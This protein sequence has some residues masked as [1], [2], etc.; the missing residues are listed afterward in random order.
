MVFVSAHWYVNGSF[1]DV[2]AKPKTIYDFFG[3]PAPLYQVEYPAPGFP[4]AIP[5]IEESFGKGYWKPVERGLDHGVWTTLVHLF[6]NADVPVITLSLNA[7]LSPEEHF[8]TGRKL[9]DLRSKGYLV[10]GGGN[11]VHDL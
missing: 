2:S 6:P 10:I 1:V 7:A 5:D 8:E 11:L 4:E 3:F 9:R